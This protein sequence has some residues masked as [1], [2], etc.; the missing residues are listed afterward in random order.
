MKAD[1]SSPTK[2]A[3]DGEGGLVKY[4]AIFSYPSTLEIQ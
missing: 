4:L 3:Y 1:E 2:I